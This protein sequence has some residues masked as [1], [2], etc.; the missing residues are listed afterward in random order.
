MPRVIFYGSNG[1]QNELDVSL[2]DTLME[3]AIDN[4]V[5]GIVAE[6]GGACAC[7]TCHTYV[8]EAWLDKLPAI[9]DMEDGM[10]DAVLDRRDNSRLACQIEITAALDGLEIHAADNEG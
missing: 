9:S 8:A 7:A 4:N 3:V 2:G 1:V 10:L 6:C 5:A